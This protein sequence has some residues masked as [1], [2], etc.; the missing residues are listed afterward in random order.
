MIGIIMLALFIEAIVSAIKPIWHDGGE[1]LSITEI[2]SICV[3]ILVAVALKI[4]LF[5]AVAGLDIDFGW[6]SP[7]WVDYMFYVMSGIAIGRGPSFIFDLWNSLKKWYEMNDTTPFVL[8]SEPDEEK[9][10]EEQN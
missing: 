4:D 10:S 2:V 7:V 9:D 3:G 8:I 5:S 6:E 1:K